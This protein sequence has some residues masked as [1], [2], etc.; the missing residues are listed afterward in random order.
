MKKIAYYIFTGLIFA[1]ILSSCEIDNFDAPDGKFYGA[2]KDSIG[3]ALVETELING[4]VIEAY[5]QGYPTEK[6]QRWLIKNNGEFRNDLVFP[7]KYNLFLRNGNFFPYSVSG[8]EIKSG[9]NQHD[10]SVV[11]YIRI[12]NSS[13]THDKAANKIV[14]TFSL[15]AGKPNVKVKAIRLYGFSDM[16]VGEAIKFNTSG[17]GFAKTF[18][19]TVLIDATTY[20][21]S[22]DLNANS[23]FFKPG[24][25]YYFR[26]GALA[27][28]QGVGTVRHN[29]VPNVKITL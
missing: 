26:I 3:G 24:R 9:E 17:A 6:L 8:F 22:I 21:L 16:Y 20:S 29:Y 2:I 7:G 18:N 15:E 25:N 19:P 13:I 1:S 5:E 23:N 28:V 27:D 14:A 4:S 10:F 12:K 11:P